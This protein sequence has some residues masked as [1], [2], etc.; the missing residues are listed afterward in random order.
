MSVA[1][2]TGAGSGF[3]R[4]T[5]LR[6]AN[7]GHSVV[8]VDIDLPS[9]HETAELAG[10]D[11]V[12]PLPADVSSSSD[13]ERIAAET[14]DRFG[15]IDQIYANAGIAGAGTAVSTDIAEWNRVIGVNLT[16]VWLTSKYLLPSMIERGRGSIVHTASVTALSGVAGV[17]AY[18]A[19][20]GGIV[21]ITRQMAVEYGPSGIRVN[22][23]CPGTVLTPLV[24]ASFAAKASGTGRSADDIIS[25]SVSRYPLGR[26]GDVGD[27][28][29]LAVFLGSEDAKWITGGIYAV[30]GGYA[31]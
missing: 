29:A 9:A 16:G 15:H 3:G 27:V 11:R 28:A 4:E 6:L 14:L 10:S 30:D 20:K 8:C 13:A 17:F 31:A 25:Q 24:Q 22:A 18:T 26:L 12:V 23:I 5:V 1:L 2:V 19:A 21:A 7:S